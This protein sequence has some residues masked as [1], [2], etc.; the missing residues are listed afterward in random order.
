MTTNLPRRT[1]LAGLAACVAS[2]AL[3]AEAQTR[4]ND[5]LDVLKDLKL[6]QALRTELEAVLP[7]KEL[8]FARTI[9][10]LVEIERE[11]DARRLK[12]TPLAFSSDVTSP[13]AQTSLYTAALPRLVALIDRSEDSDPII[14]DRAGDLLAQINQSQHVIADALKPDLPPPLHAHDFGSL[15]GEYAQYFAAAEIRPEHKDILGWYV[16]A[17]V[18]F[19]PRYDAVEK[20]TGVPWYFVGLTHAMESSLNFR[21]HLHNGDFPLTQRTRQVP[22]GRPLVWMP[23]SDWVSS[24]RDALRLMGF[25]GKTDWTLERSLYRLEAYNGFGYRKLGVPSPYLWCFSNHYERGKFVADGKWSA[26]AKSQQ[27]GA[28]VILKALAN[29]GMVEFPTTKAP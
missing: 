24:A 9:A 27:C 6:P 4:A 15:R 7:K 5:I 21:A 12:A 26:T 2:K 3:P 10:A 19:R 18:E 14:A 13:S 8:D 25:V 20:A 11:A 28:A 23:P 16:K 29:A 17:M 1:L 22:V